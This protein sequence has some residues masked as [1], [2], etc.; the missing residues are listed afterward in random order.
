MVRAM[1]KLAG[2][3]AAVLALFGGPQAVQ[4]ANKA[5]LA[6]TAWVS[7]IKVEGE[8]KGAL[9]MAFSAEDDEFLLVAFNSDGEPVK[10]IKGTYTFKNNVLTLYVDEKPFAR[11]EVTELTQTRLV[12]ED[13]KGK[14]T[15]WKRY[16]PK[17][18]RPADDE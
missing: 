16:T 12:T 4:A 17:K 1:L 5:S 15:S 10:K 11:E 8:V 7:P 9:V 2:V 6:G 13:A 18:K 14:E 3:V